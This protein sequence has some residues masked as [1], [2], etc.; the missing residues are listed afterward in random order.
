M[1]QIS[2]VKM[3]LVVVKD[4]RRIDDGVKDRE[5]RFLNTELSRIPEGV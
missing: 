5:R 3:S 4:G 1:L 2:I